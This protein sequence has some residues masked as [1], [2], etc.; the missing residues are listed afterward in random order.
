MPR[1]PFNPEL[2]KALMPYIDSSLMAEFEHTFDNVTIAGHQP[3][4]WP[5][6]F[7]FMYTVFAVNKGC[8]CNAPAMANGKKHW[9]ALRNNTKIPP[10]VR[11]HP[12]P[13]EAI[14]LWLTL[15]LYLCMWV[16][17]KIWMPKEGMP[18]DR[19]GNLKKIL[20]CKYNIMKEYGIE[21]CVSVHGV[22]GR[23]DLLADFEAALPPPPCCVRYT[24]LTHDE[25]VARE[26]ETGQNGVPLIGPAA[27]D[28]LE[29]CCDENGCEI[30]IEYGVPPHHEVDWGIRHLVNGTLICENG[31]FIVTLNDHPLQGGGEITIEI[32]PPGTL[33]SDPTNTGG[34]SGVQP[35]PTSTVISVAPPTGGVTP[36][37]QAELERQAELSYGQGPHPNLIPLGGG[38]SEYGPETFRGT[39]IVAIWCYCG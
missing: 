9:K 14:L 23:S 3:P 22:Q 30:V 38:V 25:M 7:D 10:A 36:A 13:K 34:F 15:K 5:L 33:P 35:H 18:L 11:N 29:D 24:G 1:Y 12:K 19:D 16:N 21:E 37:Q 2:Q 4:P 27:T 28:R 39:P 20:C 31:R 8:V 32:H 6:F 17:H 26:V